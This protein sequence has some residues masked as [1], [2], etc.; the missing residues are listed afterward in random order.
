[1]S[2]LPDSVQL[3]DG[4]MCQSFLTSYANSLFEHASMSLLDLSASS[5][6]NFSVGNVL[7]CPSHALIPTAQ[8]KRAVITV[9]M[10][11]HI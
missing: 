7:F 5:K 2:I 9:V 10:F 3:Y 11:A 4:I 8:K 6:P 1:M